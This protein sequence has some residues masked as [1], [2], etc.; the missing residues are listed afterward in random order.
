MYSGEAL[1]RM[2]PASSPIR[3]CYVDESGQF[4][5]RLALRRTLLQYG[6]LQ[7]PFPVMHHLRVDFTHPDL[8]TAPLHDLLIIRLYRFRKRL[9]AF[10]NSFDS[11]HEVRR[12]CNGMIQSDHSL[13]YYRSIL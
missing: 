5:L 13:V 9:L 8:L 12:V 10:R 6:A 2:S 4:N 1:G 3:F 11:P 7:H